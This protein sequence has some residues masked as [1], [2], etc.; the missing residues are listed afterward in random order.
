MK[1]HGWVTPLPG[2]LVARCG[3]PAMCKQCQDE[4]AELARTKELP[5]TTDPIAY[6]L[7]GPST[8]EE[9]AR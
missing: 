4:A 7:L 2:G 5:D 6:G 8:A 1:G 9:L 3:G